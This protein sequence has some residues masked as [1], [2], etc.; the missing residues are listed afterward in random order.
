[1]D[2]SAFSPRLDQSAMHTDLQF[3]VRLL[4]CRFRP[5]GSAADTEKSPIPQLDYSKVQSKMP[6]LVENHQQ[7]KELRS[8]WNAKLRALASSTPISADSTLSLV[9]KRKRDLNDD[10]GRDYIETVQSVK[11]C[12]IMGQTIG[13]QARFKFTSGEMC[14]KKQQQTKDGD[15]TVAVSGKLKSYRVTRDQTPL[16]DPTDSEEIET[17]KSL[18]GFNT[19]AANTEKDAPDIEVLASPTCTKSGVKI[20]SFSNSD[21]NRLLPPWRRIQ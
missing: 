4:A 19:T 3:L 17:D 7:L 8:Q 6:G 14:L 20:P 13:G 16:S 2:F 11:D 15:Y 9:K 5:P 18:S 1:M 10:A 12:K 21:R